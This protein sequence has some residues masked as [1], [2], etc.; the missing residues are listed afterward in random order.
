MIPSII[1]VAETGSD[2]PRHLAQCY[3]IHLIPMHVAFGDVTRADN[4]FSPE[5]ICTYYD[6]TGTVPRT[7]A[8]TLEDFEAVFQAI[9]AQHPKA[10]ILYLAYSA[11]ASSSFQWG[12]MAAKGKD[13]ITCLDTQQVSAGQCLVVLQ[14]AKALQDHPEWTPAQA[15]PAAKAIIQRT[16]MCFVIRSLGFLRGRGRKNNAA[17]LCGNLLRI[18]P[19]IEMDH[20]H[21]RSARKYQGSMERVIPRMIR[22]Y[23]QR[24]QLD[25][26]LL[27]LGV[28]PRLSPSA[29]RAAEDTAWQLGFQQVHWLQTGG[30]ITSHIGPGSLCMAGM[31]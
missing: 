2:I 13:Y 26:R 23:A 9:H 30:V 17:V 10:H 14:V 19:C 16:R 27:W 4:T 24:F 22:E 6:R 20:G 12:Q 29:R 3:G 18:H 15:V 8:A 7:R 5:E 25:R 28:T 31:V 1:L 11:A 21:L